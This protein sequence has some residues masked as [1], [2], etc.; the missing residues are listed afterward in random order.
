MI[1]YT[2]SIISKYPVSVYY[3]KDK[4][5]VYY[6]DEHKPIIHSY[7]YTGLLEHLYYQYD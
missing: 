4:P 3:Y 7:T 5:G 1:Y 2:N 6:C